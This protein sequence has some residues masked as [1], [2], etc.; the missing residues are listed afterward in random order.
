MITTKFSTKG[1]NYLKAMFLFV[2]LTQS[3]NIHSQSFNQYRS[4]QSGVWS[5]I[6]IWEYWDGGQWSVPFAPPDFSSNIITIQS[7]HLVTIDNNMNIDQVVVETGAQLTIAEGVSA[8]INNGGMIVRGTLLN[9]GDYLTIYGF[10]SVE[11]NATFIHNSTDDLSN[12]YY[13]F[14]L[15]ATSTFI[16]RGSSSLTP[17]INLTGGTFGNLAIESSSGS[18]STLMS[19]NAHCTIHGNLSIGTGVTITA[20]FLSPV[21]IYGNIEVNGDFIDGAVTQSITL[22]GNGKT[23]SGIGTLQLD[24]VEINS[25]ASIILQRNI[26]V[27]NQL[28]VN[29]AL[30]AGIYV[31][32]GSGGFSIINGM[33]TIGSP[34]GITLSGATGNVQVS[35][36]RFYSNSTHYVYN[37]ST[38][39]VFGNGLPS[40]FVDVTIANTGGIALPNNFS[41]Q[42][43]VVNNG[44]QL[45]TGPY[46]FSAITALIAGILQI[47][48]G[49]AVNSALNYTS[50]GVLRYS[51]SYSFTATYNELFNA[52]TVLIQNGASVQYPY[53]FANSA[54]VTIDENS[55]LEMQGA[56]V[57]NGSIT[58]NGT[59]RMNGFFANG[60]NFVYGNNGKL[61]ILYSNTITSSS[62]F[63][64]TINGPSEIYIQSPL[65]FGDA[66]VVNGQINVSSTITNSGYL[67]VNGTLQLLSNGNLDV[68]PVYGGSSTLIY[69]TS[70]NFSRG[71][72]WQATT[73]S[74]IYIYPNTNLSL[75]SYYSPITLGGNITISASAELSMPHIYSNVIFQGNII[76]NGTFTFSPNFGTT[77]YLTANF[78]NNGTINSN[79]RL[80]IL[81]GSSAQSLSGIISLPYLTVNN[82]SGI[83]LN[84]D[85]I[86][87][88]SLTLSEGNIVTGANKVILGAG[89]NV[90]RTNG[91]IIGYL[92]KN[93]PIGN[94]TVTYEIGDATY[95]NP[96][97][98]AFTNVTSSGDITTI[99]LPGE[100]HD[101]NYSNLNGNKR[102]N[103]KWNVTNSGTNFSAYDITL[104]FN[105][106]ELQGGANPAHLF[107]GKYDNAWQY[108]TVGVR[109]GTSTQ[110]LGITSFGNYVI[111][112][113]N[114]FTITASINGN[115]TINPS[116]TIYK[117]YLESQTF[118]ITPNPNYHISSVIVDGVN[119]GQISSYT[120]NNIATNHTIEAFT[121]INSH[122]LTTTANNGNITRNPNASSYTYGTDVELTAL[123]NIGYHFVNW[124]GDATGT[125]NPVTINMNADKNVTANFS[126]NTYTITATAGPNGSISPNGVLTNN[127]GTNR[128]FTITADAHYHI[129]D[130]LVNGVSVGTPNSYTFTNITTNHTI[131]VTF[132]QNEYTL[133]LNAANGTITKNPNAATY[134]YGNIVTLTAIPQNMYYEFSHWS[135]DTSGTQNPR[136]IFIDGNK[137]ITA[138]FIPY[139]FRLLA[140]LSPTRNAVGVPAS[141][142]III[143]FSFPLN[144]GTVT[145]QSL[146]VIGSQTGNHSGSISFTNSNKDIV[147]NP[148]VDFK[149]GEV[150]YVILTSG[151]RSIAN[152]SLTNGYT[153]S[154]TIATGLATGNFGNPVNYSFAWG[155][156][157]IASGDIDNDGDIDLVAGSSLGFVV[158]RNNGIGQFYPSSTVSPAQTSTSTRDLILRDFNNDGY[159]DVAFVFYTIEQLRIH[160]NDGNGNF[161]NQNGTSYFAP[162]PEGLFAGDLNNDG[163][164][165]IVTA[166]YTNNTIHVFMNIGF[167]SFAQPVVYSG[168][169]INSIPVDVKIADFN[170]D[171]YNDIVILNGGA[172]TFVVYLNNGNGTLTFSGSYSAGISNR[173]VDVGDIDTDGDIDLV[174]TEY[175]N[176]THVSRNN[177][178]GT[179]AP[180]TTYNIGSQPLYLT[181]GDIEGDNDLDL[182]IAN[183]ANNNTL[184]LRNDGSGSFGNIASYPLTHS[185]TKLTFADFDNDGDL[186]FAASNLH[187]NYVNVYFNIDSVVTPTVQS[188]AMVFPGKTPTTITVRVNKGNGNRRI[189]LARQGTAVNGYPTDQTN[190]TANSVF[191]SGSQI[192]TG[193]YVVYAGTDSIITVTG[194]QNSTNYHFAAFEYNGNNGSQKYLQSSPAVG[195][196]TTFGPPPSVSALKSIVNSPTAITFRGVVNPNGEETSFRFAYG[197]NI[198]SLTDTSSAQNIGNGNS[199]ET[200]TF[201]ATGLTT[202]NAY[203]SRLIATSQSGTTVGPISVIMLDNST[204]TKTN[205]NLWLRADAGTSTTIHNAQVT[206]WYDVS[207]NNNNATQTNN[208]H[209]RPYYTGN[210]FNGRPAIFFN[211]A[212]SH[213]VL[214]TAGTIGLQNS[215]YEIF[216]VAGSNYPNRIDFLFSSEMGEFEMHLGGSAGVRMIPRN[217]TFYLDKGV[218]NDYQNGLPHI[219]STRVSASF[220]IVRVNGEDGGIN[221][222]D[223]RLSSSNYG[224]A[225]GIRQGGSYPFAGAIS[226]M[227]IYNRVLSTEERD[228][229]ESYLSNKYGITHMLP[230]ELTHFSATLMKGKVELKWNTATEI[231]NYGFEIERKYEESDPVNLQSK[232]GSWEKVGFVAG[233]GNSNSAKE[234]SFTDKVL[235]EGSVSYRLKQIDSDGSFSYS[236]EI[237]V[238]IEIP[239]N[240]VLYQNYPNPFNPTT[241]IEFTL[242]EDGFTLLKVYDIFG[243]EVTTLVKQELR[244][245]EIHKVEFDATGL[246]SG[247]YFYR[248]ESKNQTQIKKLIFLK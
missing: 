63:W 241:T 87:T 25:S 22:M 37:A 240:F 114:P 124:S 178:N 232:S 243:G 86:I 6:G 165:D 201:S 163:R 154:F 245:G 1:L 168:I 117:N 174:Y 38:A 10:I 11:S 118:T 217:N 47:D 173:K 26:T 94:P 80:V 194:L 200:V 193:N 139:T 129:A 101:F 56:V 5:N 187:S 82:G 167:S 42:N 76:N 17:T 8:T 235:K 30:N 246:A 162:T 230:V 155:S 183:M 98:L 131:S 227:L 89:A 3:A 57:N 216:I 62:G 34:E 221:N 90:N 224:I 210:M 92:Q 215:D 107:I 79:N 148:N 153:Y 160:W 132:A 223:C 28:Q 123:P 185:P 61:R 20:T 65:S 75:G 14:Q 100:T 176:R 175:N 18:F 73:P 68:S 144:T 196:T 122:T 191:G 29:G 199:S 81:N 137:N 108:P 12:R 228:Q 197:T 96:I 130:V 236:N 125:N 203:Y 164:L 70:G 40:N 58:V 59:F 212:N 177:G 78:T 157:C 134:N 156:N 133:T 140:N 112:E 206:T 189:I 142:N 234:Y 190:Y 211:G 72:E 158:Q 31:I 126:I 66:R 19:G 151:I 60:N 113:H 208:I 39:Q 214:P 64:P 225:V 226:E 48:A 233:N 52:P 172:F 43:L 67:T 35:G 146:Q 13:Y 91:H 71:S 179:F 170:S 180:R 239:K 188:S 213:F 141:S 106:S 21:I 161:T 83:T 181:L 121:T 109:A 135:G 150:V 36:T 15:H 195:N 238:E 53:S 184:I 51:G 99:A 88:S 105:P 46:Y 110:G 120:F 33:L 97:Q 166:N 49:G 186:D 159:L 85:L 244:A 231:D 16:F 182:G 145:A 218:V 127:H 147:F 44:S 84:S 169:D 95:Y 55:T 32:S 136:T 209:W 198:N 152:D 104:N 205:L 229:V 7:G 149:P 219:F 111:A 45:N 204:F 138:N 247:I 143:P 77:I 102:V 237:K 2:F 115:G 54:N 202:N 27:L 119:Q 4:T 24:Y 116:G 222:N 103:R 93:I 69:N 207:G 74:S 192:G 50:T 41:F 248:L 220:G 9:H 242:A 171:G 128:T 23:I